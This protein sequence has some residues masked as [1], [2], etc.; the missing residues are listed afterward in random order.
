MQQIIDDLNWRYA[1]KK[2]D[3]VKKLSEQQ[4]ET[5]KESIRLSA[6]SYGLQAYK[7]LIITDPEIREALMEASHG[8]RPVVDAS[9]LFVFCAYTKVSEADVAKYIQLISLT[10]GTDPNSLIGFHNGIVNSIKNKS[11]EDIVA[12]TSKQTYIALGQLMHT[13]ASLRVDALPMEGFV[14]SAY[15]EILGLD[16]LNLTATLACPV[17]FRHE[18]DEAQ[19]RKKVR[20]SNEDLFEIR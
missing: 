19:F 3:P 9:H 8:Q 2:F 7:V 6:S 13:C 10:R 4:M 1:T 14:P 11:T 16:E 12:W 5:L 17:G 18:A 20:K 15:N